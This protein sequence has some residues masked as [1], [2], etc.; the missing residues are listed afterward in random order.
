MSNREKEKLNRYRERLAQIVEIGASED[1]VSRGYDFG[2][3]FVIVVALVVAVLDT[4]SEAYSR[5]GDL[6]NGIEAVTSVLFLIDY[7]LRI[8]ASPDI[9]PRA[10]EG[11]SVLAYIGSFAGVVDLLSFLPFFFPVYFPNGA[12]SFRVFR[13]ARI[14]RLF[15]INAYYDS[16]NAITEVLSRKKQQL[17]SSVFVIL[18]LMLASS[19]CMYSVE[20]DAQPEIFR[21]AFSGIWWAAST[22]LTVGYGDI[23]PITTIGRILGIAITFLGVGMVAIPTGIISAGF[24]EQYSQMQAKG[25]LAGE[26]E[27]DFFRFQLSSEDGWTGK[28]V[29]DLR[30]PK[31]IITTVVYRRHKV[32]LPDPDLLLKAGDILLLSARPIPGEAPIELTELVLTRNHPWTGQF[33]HDLKLSRRTVIVLIKRE[34]RAFLPDSST[35]LKTGDLLWIHTKLAPGG[36][37]EER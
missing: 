4:Y 13:I 37:Q 1:K 25:K 35:K 16:L 36:F 23:Y 33:I 31:G 17:L 15:R 28:T 10:T 30:L 22:L 7:I 19:L 32:L 24:V 21:N 2:I 8:I 26:S 12:I 9:Y 18:V 6:L 34:G 3:T 11:R 20:H 29:R 5:Y 27:L 14:F